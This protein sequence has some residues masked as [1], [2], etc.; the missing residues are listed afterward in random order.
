MHFLQKSKFMKTRVRNEQTRSHAASV[1][2]SF[3]LE[4]LFLF[5]QEKRKT[6]SF[7]LFL[8]QV[9]LVLPTSNHKEPNIFL[10]DFHL[11]P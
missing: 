10:T 11:A 2:Q 8:T 1:E 6:H 5:F 3:L 7:C 9:K 4:F